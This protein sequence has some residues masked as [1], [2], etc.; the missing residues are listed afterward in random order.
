MKNKSGIIVG[1]CV[2]SEITFRR[3]ADSTLGRSVRRKAFPSG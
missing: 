1:N 2:N 3:L